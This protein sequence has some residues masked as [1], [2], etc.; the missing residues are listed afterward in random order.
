MEAGDDSGT[1]TADQAGKFCGSPEVTNMESCE[2][3]IVIGRFAAAQATPE[4]CEGGGVN[5]ATGDDNAAG[6]D[7]ISSGVS[8]DTD[9]DKSCGPSPQRVEFEKTSSIPFTIKIDLDTKVSRS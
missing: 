3:D 5:A 2:G 9:Q 8:S 6:G 7:D 4:F 1:F